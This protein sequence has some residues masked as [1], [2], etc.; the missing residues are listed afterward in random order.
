M[1]GCRAVGSGLV[2]ALALG[3]SSSACNDRFL[4]DVAVAGAGG[5]ADIAGGSFSG[6][7]GS[8]VAGG[9]AESGL[10]GRGGTTASAGSAGAIDFGG[11]GSPPA[12]CGDLAACPAELHCADG[13]CSQ[14]ATDVDCAAPGLPRCEPMRHRCV[15]CVTTAD[16]DTGFAC[17]SLANRCLKKCGTDIDCKGQHGCDEHRL[18]CY[19][20]DEDRECDDSPLG[21]LCASDG[22]GCVQCRKDADCP[23]QH[24]DQLMGRCVDCRDGLDCP[25]RL[26]SPATFT[27]LPS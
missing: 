10:G 7:T 22:S 6:A 25:S 19:Q 5:T 24:C 12:A 2:L 16:C 3:V 26:C 20:C 15:A 1:S 8:G 14:C 11:S 21:A 4:F 18:V 27:C 23:S 13:L 9:G 17:D